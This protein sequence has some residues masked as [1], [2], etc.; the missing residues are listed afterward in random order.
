M[1]VAKSSQVNEIFDEI[2]YCKGAACIMMITAYLG[3]ELFRK[4]ICSYL[5][6]HKYGNARTADLWAALTEA[7]GKDVKAFMGVWTKEVGYPV[8]SLSRSG[9]KLNMT[10]ARFLS[11]G[12]EIKQ[13]NAW[14]VPMS[15]LDS[16]AQCVTC[17]LRSVS[18]EVDGTPGM[19]SDWV[20][21]NAGQ[22]GF[23]RIRYSDELL[24]CLGDAIESIKLSPVDRLGVQSDAFALAKAGQLPTDRA[25]ALA[26]R[27][28][29]EQDFT[30]W[31]DLAGSLGDVMGTWAKEDAEYQQ[32]QKLLLKVMGKIV[33]VVGWTPI[34]GEHALFPMLRPLIIGA[35]G[36]NGH[37]DVKKE[38]LARMYSSEGWQSVPADL[39]FA[40]FSIVVAH[41]GVKGFDSVL[42]VFKEAD[43]A[44]ERVRALRGL[45]YARE[46]EL[47]DR[48]LQMT[49]D[50]SIRAQDVFYV[51]GT[52][53]GNRYAMDRAWEFIKTNWEAICKM[54]SSGQFLLGRILK[55]AT[56]AF[57]SEAK[58]AE[59]EAFFKDKDTP[60][61]ERSIS[62]ALETIR[63][64]AQWLER[65]RAVVK[66]WLASNV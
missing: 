61:A 51:Y 45:G 35:V 14:W 13:A 44:E 52:L 12:K 46:P 37:E 60:G 39:R 29:N 11:N 59:V 43:M 21:G 24:A 18:G 3:M 55:S 41:G 47:I 38:A 7:S 40:V 34:A 32:L 42:K 63:L 10:Q 49:L 8:V 4:G 62:Q 26:T 22:T 53:A 25:L 2:S 1:H 48:L 5:E 30:V 15:L 64:N 56:S 23:Y 58:A 6:K 54:F 27:Y 36:R 17:D 66:A 20:K 65:D 28:I 33:D 16:A 50:D 57:T 19:A 31:S 9:G